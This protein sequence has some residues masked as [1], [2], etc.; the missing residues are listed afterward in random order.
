MRF[1]IGD[2]STDKDTNEK[3]ITITLSNKYVRRIKSAVEFYTGDN[4]D[5]QNTEL[6][7]SIRAD[8]HE[9]WKILNPS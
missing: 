9:T 8:I 7:E 6:M 2:I 5:N 1:T 4:D 3:Y